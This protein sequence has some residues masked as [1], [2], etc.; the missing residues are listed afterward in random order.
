MMKNG[1][2]IPIEGLE[3]MLGGHAGVTDPSGTVLFDGIGA[4]Q[5][6]VHINGPV[7]HY[8]ADLDFD[9]DT[10]FAI[11][12]TP[13]SYLFSFN[14]YD[15]E[16]GDSLTDLKI[17]WHEEDTLYPFTDY[18]RSYGQFTY[19]VVQD[20]IDLA[21]G[22]FLLEA[23][24]LL[25]HDVNP[26]EV[27]VTFYLYDAYDSTTIDDGEIAFD[28]HV[29][30]TSAWGDL[31]VDLAPGMYIFS[32]SADNY[33]PQEQTV[34][35]PPDDT[36]LIWWMERSHA[37]VK[38]ILYH[39]GTPVNEAL[40]RVGEHQQVSNALGMVTFMDL[41]V[42]TT[43][44]YSIERDPYVFKEGTL[45]L[46]HDTVV[47]VELLFSGITN[48][49]HHRVTLYPQP[50]QQVLRI[51]APTGIH[52]LTLLD[53]TGRRLRTEEVRNRTDVVLE[54]T[55]LSAGYYLLVMQ[56]ADHTLVR[57]KIEIIR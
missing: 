33:H 26:G 23:D 39:E 8:H 45:L 42:D 36:T 1:S 27:E 56:M 9:S 4:D 52:Q 21:T 13:S 18:L 19:R 6:D 14:I 46:V 40:V 43:Y 57:K 17:I 30:T 37:T 5:D 20:E 32:V 34:L 2:S 28:D 31:S 54:L 49:A 3:V 16:T 38:F 24:T 10:T 11:Y 41:K 51:D 48:V 15:H 25:V 7:Y 12:L 29:Y 22:T 44:T 47:E 35:L 53:L 50:A 55:G